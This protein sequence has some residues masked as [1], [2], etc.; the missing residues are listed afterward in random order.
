MR[1][2]IQ[3]D[4][5]ICFPARVRWHFPYRLNQ[6]YFA[7]CHQYLGSLPVC[8]GSSCSLQ[9]TEQRYFGDISNSSDSLWHC[10]W[11]NHRR[12]CQLFSCFS[13]SGRLS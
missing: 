3:T 7:R 11:R 5:L 8:Y 9:L 1:E 12:H 6:I 13:F 10:S 4:T 2:N